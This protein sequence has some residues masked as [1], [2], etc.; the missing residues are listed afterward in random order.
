M[1]FLT[2]IMLNR[3]D[4]VVLAFDPIHRFDVSGDQYVEYPNY[5]II[6]GKNKILQWYSKVKLSPQWL[7][8]PVVS[9]FF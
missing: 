2:L 4:I 8:H 5:A 6:F 7:A 1:L 3:A 9:E